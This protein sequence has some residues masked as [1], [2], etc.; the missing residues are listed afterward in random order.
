MLRQNANRVSVFF[1]PDRP[2][3]KKFSASVLQGGLPNVLTK[4]IR[5]P[6]RTALP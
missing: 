3:A 6:R 5:P 4:K 2:T 1:A